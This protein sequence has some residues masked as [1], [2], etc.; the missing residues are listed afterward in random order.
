MTKIKMAKVFIFYCCLILISYGLLYCSEGSA[1][2]V[3]DIPMTEYKPNTLISVDYTFLNEGINQPAYVKQN[4]VTNEIIVTD[5]GNNCVYFFDEK[6][7]FLRKSGRMGQGPGEFLGPRPFEFD[8]DGRVYIYEDFNRRMSILSKEG[9][10]I[11]SF[12]VEKYSRF[13]TFWV[14]DN[15]EILV[16]SPKCGYYITVFNEKGQ[17]V[18]KIGAIPNQLKQIRAG[19]DIFAEALIF[20]DTDNNYYAFHKHQCEIN[21]WDENGKLIRN[22]NMEDVLKGHFVNNEFTH[23]KDYERQR[24]N[25][26]KGILPTRLMQGVFFNGTNFYIKI[27]PDYLKSDAVAFKLSKNFELLEIYSFRGCGDLI[28]YNQEMAVA[29]DNTSFFFPIQKNSEILVFLPIK[30]EPLIY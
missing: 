10:Y 4:P 2:A 7:I 29:N 17:V 18:R 11:T 12:R 21:V 27:R 9:E 28:K 26:L 30:S 5:F 19:F 6:G 25:G 23:Y 20:S 8:R 15:K 22:Y 3:N 1:K 24:A 16:N 13:S 14:T